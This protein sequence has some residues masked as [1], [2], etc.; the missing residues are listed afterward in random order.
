M[1]GRAD[2]EMMLGGGIIDVF[3]TFEKKKCYFNRDSRKGNVACNANT[4]MSKLA[5]QKKGN[6]SLVKL[7]KIRRER[8][9]QVQ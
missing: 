1:A 8:N 7:P 2:E 5:K 4:L 9:N 6:S 3:F